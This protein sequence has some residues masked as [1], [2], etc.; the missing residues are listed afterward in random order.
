MSQFAAR[1]GLS[2]QRIHQHLRAH[3]IV[4]APVKVGPYWV[5][6]D[7]ARIK[8]GRPVGRAG[9]RKQLTSG[10]RHE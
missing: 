10:K 4:P 8:P 3:R 6:S 5:F 2:K 7:R 9:W 1:C